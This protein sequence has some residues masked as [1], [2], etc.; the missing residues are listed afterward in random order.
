MRTPAEGTDSEY[1]YQF[2]REE[3]VVG[4]SDAADLRLPDR[5][6][7][8][9]HA[10]LR[11]RGEQL[12]VSDLNSTNG[13]RA[14]GHMVAPGR[15]RKVDVGSQI[16]IGVFALWIVR[17]E[18]RALTTGRDTASYARQMVRDILKAVGG[19]GDDAGDSAPRL[20]VETGPRRGVSQP[21]RG[22]R[23]VCVGRGQEC[24][25]QLPDADASRRHV[26]VSLDSEGV[27]AMDLGSKNG[28]VINGKAT[29]EAGKTGLRLQHGDVLRVGRT[30]VRFV[31]PTEAALSE[32]GRGADASVTAAPRG[33][34]QMPAE[35][36]SSSEEVAPDAVVRRAKRPTDGR[37]K[38][39]MDLTLLLLAV[40]LVIAAAA[41]VTYLIG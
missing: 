16:E 23:P 6:V 31:D 10:R 5:S 19:G 40:G 13:T 12:L 35:E 7:S 17:P 25:L 29:D 1:R 18:D 34:E 8:L 36:V 28:L 3:V 4:R 22:E 30:S 33:A 37:S 20:E 41:A 9:V 27:L 24:D 14:D 15:R 2:D 39:R 26:Q 38:R 11:F 21:L 32:L